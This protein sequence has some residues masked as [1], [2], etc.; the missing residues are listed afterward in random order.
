MVPEFFQI[1]ARPDQFPI[2][3]RF[4]I[5]SQ[6]L[7]KMMQ[8]ATFKR[9]DT[10][11]TI[12]C[13][14]FF[15]LLQ[16]KPAVIFAES[17]MMSKFAQFFASIYRLTA[18]DV[19]KEAFTDLYTILLQQSSSISTELAQQFFLKC[20]LESIELI[21]R[22]EFDDEHGRKVRTFWGIKARELTLNV[23]IDI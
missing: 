13:Q 14:H 11:K 20:S 23:L 8:S 19:W 1:V 3:F 22:T 12:V 17:A 16:T 15:D 4:W 9:E 10:A 2:D 6:A 21:K 7:P 18:V 5:I